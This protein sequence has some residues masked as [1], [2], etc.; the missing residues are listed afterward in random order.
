MKY[1]LM[2][3]RFMI[4][5]CTL[6]LLLSGCAPEIEQVEETEQ[7]Y[8]S[9][10][11]I[12]ALS[13]LVLE[14][15]PGIRLKCL[16]QPQDDCLRLYDLSDWDAS[17]LAYDADAIIIGGSGLESFESALYTF[18]DGGPAVITATYGLS[19][20][21]ADGD[22]GVDGNTGHLSDANPHL[23]MSITG[24]RSMLGVIAGALEELYPDRAD[25]IAANAQ[26]ADDELAKLSRETKAICADAEGEK[27]IIM[28]EALIYPALEYALTVSYRYD[29]ESG[30]TLYGTGLADAISAFDETGARVILI[31]KQAPAELIQA[32][33]DAGYTVV[34]I[35]I[36]SAYSSA[37]DAH[38]YIE[39][40]LSNA[41]AIADAFSA[42]NAE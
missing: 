20:F 30:T 6:A 12:Y 13:G 32:L 4:L 17:V 11:P 21:N 33:E 27:V 28:N 29:R 7:I 22:A 9:F 15:V 26:R 39:T 34:L 24:A 1:R 3:Y 38:A 37:D 16:V 25:E 35:D 41:Q 31:E 36:M 42:A 2:K 23:Y 5:L 14:D 19:L 8:A 10:Y 40:Q 18:G